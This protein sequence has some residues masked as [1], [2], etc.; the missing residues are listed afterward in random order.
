MRARLQYEGGAR[1]ESRM[2]RDKRRTL[3]KAV[4][5]SYQSGDISKIPHDLTTL[6]AIEQI[7]GSLTEEEQKIK[8]ELLQES[9]HYRRAL[10]NPDKVK[11]DYDEKI[12]SVPFECGI[13]PGDIIKWQDTNTY[14]LSY[15]PQL[16]EDAYY[17]SSLRRCRYQITW[18]DEENNIHRTWAA[19]RGPV[20]TRIESIHRQ[21]TIVDIPNLSLNILVPRTEATLKMFKRYSRF[22][23]DD[24]CWLIEAHD[25]ISMENVIQVS[26][27][28]NYINT[29]TDDIENDLVNGLIISKDEDIR[30]NEEVYITGESL[31]EPSFVYSYTIV[32]INDGFWSIKNDCPTVQIISIENNTINLKW[33]SMKSGQ[34]TLVYENE[35]TTIEKNIRVDSLF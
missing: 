8:D 5:Y 22:I 24:V 7:K 16:S 18:K 25:T 32:G 20:E 3:D 21:E 15:L 6:E 17:R 33:N 30:P 10:I 2:I 14:W 12:L 26:A 4:L 35:L 11:Q 13:G 19:I 31:I 9:L 34:F 1:Q 28:E 29:Q 27:V 23:F